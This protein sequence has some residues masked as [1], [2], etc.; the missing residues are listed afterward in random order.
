MTELL[1]SSNKICGLEVKNVGIEQKFYIGK[2]VIKIK[3]F[4]TIMT[5]VFLMFSLVGCAKLVSTEYE[6]VE[7]KI[8]DV[9]YKPSYTT[10]TYDVALKM[11]MVQSHP[12]V[13]R[14]TIEYNGI[15]YTLSD[16]DTYNKYK[17]KV[18]QTAIGTLEI[19]TYDDGTVKY[20]ITELE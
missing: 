17:D 5:I 6:N 3:K 15:E 13:Y 4:I 20:D 11:P 9:Y 18:G 7:V 8:T 12:A 10:T 19:R 14:V 2:E 1:E 16:S